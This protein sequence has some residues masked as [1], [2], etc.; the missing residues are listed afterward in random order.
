MTTGGGRLDA[1]LRRAAAVVRGGGVLVYPTETVYGIGCDPFDAVAVERVRAIKGRE[2]TKP[3]L[4]LTDTWDR[5]AGWVT[6]VTDTHRRVMGATDGA[7]RPLA[8]TLLFEAGTDA[9]ASLVSA[10]GLIGLRRTPDP[11]GQRLVAACS[12]ALLS[13]SANQAGQPPAA[14]FAALDPYVVEAADYALDAGR[15]LGGTPSTVVR[16]EDG[17]LVVVRAGAVD[18]RTLREIVEG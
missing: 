10:A 7:G 16:V 6:G 12:T 14:S 3:M 9:P 15:D 1:A 8:V 2:A 11:L 13:T 18:A 17:A 5:V 4:A